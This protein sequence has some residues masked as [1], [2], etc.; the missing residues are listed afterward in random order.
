MKTVFQIRV[1]LDYEKDVFRDLEIEATNTFAQ[2]HDL[3]Q[4]AFA[5][6]NQQMASF[7]KSNEDWEQ[8][9]EITLMDVG[10]KDEK[11]DPTLLMSDVTI[12]S[13]LENKAD[14]MIYV[15]DFMLMWCFYLDLIEITEVED[16]MILPQIV[17]S[18]GDAPGQYSKSDKFL[19]D[20]PE[21][22]M[23]EEEEP[24]EEDIF[25]EMGGGEEFDY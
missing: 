12:G 6:D 5:F 8:G 21:P 24:E 23:D 3:I 20:H 16:A 10:G 1:V 17:Q 13:Q 15:F 7:Y 22:D 14:K 11:G 2:L 9:L 19:F 18:F 4:E 25:G